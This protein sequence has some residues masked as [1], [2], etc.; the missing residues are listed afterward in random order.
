MN[1]KTPFHW[2]IAVVSIMLI[3]PPKSLAQQPRFRV[4]DLTSLGDFVPDL[5]PELQLRHGTMSINNLGQV[6]YTRDVN[7]GLFAT[8][9][10]AWF[11]FPEDAFGQ[12]AGVHDLHGPTSAA[13]DIS[14][15]GR[16][17]GQVDAING[18]IDHVSGQAYL[19]W[20]THDA[21]APPE[22][23]AIPLGYLN[24]DM[25]R[26]YSIAYAINDEVPPVIVGHSAVD[27]DEPCDFDSRAFVRLY[28][29]EPNV[30]Q[31]LGALGAPESDAE[32]SYARD[33]ST[34]LSEIDQLIGGFSAR[35]AGDTSPSLCTTEV[36]CYP[37]E[38]STRW[39]LNGAPSAPFAMPQVPS[40]GGHEVRG[41]NNLYELVGQGYES[42]VEDPNCLLHATFWTFNEITDLHAEGL[43]PLNQQSRAEAINNRSPRQVVG[44]N[45]STEEA[46]IWEQDGSGNW[47]PAINVN[48][49]IGSAGW[50]LRDAHDINDKGCIVGWGYPDYDTQHAHAFL[51]Y[52]CLAD[53]A[54]N[55][56]VVN[57]QDFLALL[58]GWGGVG[59]P[60][61]I[62]GGG[63]GVTDFL[64]LLGSWGPCCK[65][66]FTAPPVSVSDCIEMFGT[67]DLIVLEECICKVEPQQCQ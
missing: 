48:D 24:S 27:F 46:Y 58:Q 23:L 15:T 18:D 32:A 5:L 62:D 52:E 35:S 47:M 37:D 60:C 55:D 28:G 2:C 12:T 21:P 67:E 41:V 50:N 31:A 34:S 66:G 57:V 7:P 8:E 49:E 43:I 56:R 6:V 51:L 11:Y 17:V 14:N 59:T 38:K 63:V 19:W 42:A 44:Q 65:V 39:I 4:F 1:S 16:A 20:F 25:D 40:G 64:T 9:M 61:D 54:N 36:P 29:Q 45:I 26:K 22:I 3:P 13:W 30:M 33:V 10:R 53:C